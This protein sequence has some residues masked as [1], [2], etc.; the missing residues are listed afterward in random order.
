M[1][2][3][4]STALNKRAAGASYPFSAAY[5]SVRPLPMTLL[6]RPLVGEAAEYNSACAN[7]LRR[8]LSGNYSPA[9][10]ETLGGRLVFKQ[11]EIYA[12]L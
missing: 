7:T 2:N 5:Y 11:G 6:S 1:G 10:K 3:V 9:A 4:S 12:V 8:S